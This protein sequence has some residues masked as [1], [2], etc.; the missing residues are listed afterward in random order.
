MRRTILFTIAILQAFALDAAVVTREKASSVA[1]NFFGC[2]ITKSAQE[3]TLEW[4][5]E[6]FFVFNRAGGG[7]IIISAEDQVSPILGFSFDGELKKNNLT[8]PLAKWLEGVHS[9]ILEA[10]NASA[11]KSVVKLRWKNALT[12]T[13]APQEDVTV[14]KD[15]KTARWNQSLPFNLACPAVGGNRAPAGC[16]PVAMA[17]IL[18]YYQYP[19]K[20]IGWIPAYKYSDAELTGGAVIQV[21]EKRFGNTYHWNLMKEYYGNGYSDA[22]G[23]AVA[24]LLYDCG[25]A[26]TSEYGKDAT[27]ANTPYI[28]KAAEDH[29]FYQVGAQ[30]VFRKDYTDAQ[31]E[32]LL[33]QE[34]DGNHP[35][36]Y[37][38]TR[39]ESAHCFVMDGYGTYQGATFFKI[40]WGWGGKDNGFYSVDNMGK[41][42]GEFA[43]IIN[44]RPN[45]EGERYHSLVMGKN[46]ELTGQ[47]ASGAEISIKAPNI[48]NAGNDG[49][50]G[51]I[52]PAV[53][54]KY[55]NIKYYID[56]KGKEVNLTP[57]ASTAAEFKGE[58]KV[59]EDRDSI[60]FVYKSVGFDNLFDVTTAGIKSKLPLVDFRGLSQAT[61]IAYECNRKTLQITTLAGAII[62]LYDNKGTD[63]SSI[64]TKVDLLTYSVFF[65]S[66]GG[67]FNVVIEKAG[68]KVSFKVI[69]NSNP[70]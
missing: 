1:S 47:V 4:Q 29:F 49:F 50:Q 18:Y 32:S 36:I 21:P 51:I 53:F 59:L 8:E 65:G 68:E 35:M 64:V 41:Y 15:L 27:S 54:D 55:G 3:L 42:T 44:L 39:D 52:R 26:L 63:L 22:E 70:I 13:K 45:P 12:A 10:R 60:G 19:S 46:I 9:D 17:E 23:A 20:S 43:A 66:E 37:R 14:V 5:D 34:L 56:E 33:K 2:G 69:I 58:L 67:T 24:Q 48:V 16:V 38:G 30:Y 11:Q 57:G 28:V 6:A 7:F 31:W 62:K 25:V 40:N 61:E